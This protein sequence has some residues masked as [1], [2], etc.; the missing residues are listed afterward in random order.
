MTFWQKMVI[1]I[2]VHVGYADKFESN[3][4]ATEYV[5]LAQ[6]FLICLEMLF[7]ATAHCFVFSPDEWAEGYR[8]IEENRRKQRC[9]SE[10]HFGDGVALHDF[11]QDV[12]V[13]IASKQRRK[14]R[15][16]LKRD[17]V[18]E[19]LTPSSTTSKDDDEQDETFDLALS[20]SDGDSLD[21]EDKGKRKASTLMEHM[22]VKDGLEKKYS[23]QSN[24]HNRHDDD[25]LG[26]ELT[27]DDEYEIELSSRTRAKNK[28]KIRHRLDTGSSCGSDGGDYRVSWA[29]IEKYINEHGLDKSG[30]SMNGSTHASANNKDSSKE[31]V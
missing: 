23:A 2:I 9:Q 24:S 17:A 26:R 7:A 20:Q 16:R 19:T 29:R 5:K 27:I 30:D 10:S 15:R 4:E 3:D 25:Q 1:S 22:D 6:N 21:G 13:V 12:K 18:D 28:P 11:I 8:E 31:I 14:R